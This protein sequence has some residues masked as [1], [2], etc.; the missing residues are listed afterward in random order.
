MI[1][2]NHIAYRFLTDDNFGIE[3]LETTHPEGIKAIVDGDTK[4]D[5]NFGKMYSLW[6][7]V[8]KDD[9]KAYWITNTVLD[10][11]D[12]LKVKKKMVGDEEQYDW[13]IFKNITDQ[14]LSYIFPNNSVLRVKIIDDTIH[15]C[16][17]TFNYDKGSDN[18]GEAYWVIFFVDRKTN[19]QC[20]H[21]AHEDVKNIE[22]FVYSLMIFF[23]LSD[24]EYKVIE[25]NQK[26]GTRKTGKIINTLN[27][28]ITVVN[29]NW[30]I[31]SIRT[32][33]FQVKGHFAVR[34]TGEGRQTPRVVF[35]EPFM[36]KGYV[37]GARKDKELK[38]LKES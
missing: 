36:K 9:Q 15:F 16:Y 34:W 13:T 22:K 28:P 24:N 10:K 26:Y 12:M 23:F 18:Y 33:G 14:K 2:K 3:I 20:E 11:L 38:E 7:L 8:N 29:S 19:R 17:L 1:L 32:D 5:E 37:R 30:N 27:V 35:I 31:T 4:K 6:Q 25:P 21:F